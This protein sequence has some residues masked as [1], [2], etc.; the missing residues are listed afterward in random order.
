MYLNVY[1]PGCWGW[2]RVGG[3]AEGP[4]PPE[5]RGRLTAAGTSARVEGWG[6]RAR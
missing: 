3:E 4:P 5:G 2:S 6:Q 1:T